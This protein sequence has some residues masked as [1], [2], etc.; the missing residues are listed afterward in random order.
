MQKF[1]N[2]TFSVL[3]FMAHGNKSAEVLEFGSMVIEDL[4]LFTFFLTFELGHLYK[5][6]GIL[7]KVVTLDYGAMDISQY[8]VIMSLSAGSVFLMILNIAFVAMGF[9]FYREFNGHAEAVGV[10]GCLIV[11]FRK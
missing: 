1:I 6:P 7:S 5:L 8:Q 3:F 4:Q 10:S 11:M 2:I 9:F